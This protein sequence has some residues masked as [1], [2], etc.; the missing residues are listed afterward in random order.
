MFCKYLTY[1]MVNISGKYLSQTLLLVKLQKYKYNQK[2]NQN[3]NKKNMLLHFCKLNIE[4]D[5]SQICQ[6]NMPSVWN[7][8]PSSRR[9]TGKYGSVLL[10][11]KSTQV[12]LLSSTEEHWVLPPGTPRADN[13][14]I[15]RKNHWRWKGCESLS[16]SNT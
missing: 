12:L 8:R 13:E 5:S 6:S 2:P 3:N 4:I 10:L 9:N 15:V 11:L 1:I 7:K 16:D 14:N